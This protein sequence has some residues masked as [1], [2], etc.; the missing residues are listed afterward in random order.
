M[1][2]NAWLT[3]AGDR[4]A[5]RQLELLSKCRIAFKFQMISTVLCAWR[6]FTKTKMEA[7]KM[8]VERWA[9]WL[10]QWFELVKHAVLW[11]KVHL[12][13]LEIGHINRLR[14]Y[15][16]AFTR[17]VERLR[18]QGHYASKARLLVGHVQDEAENQVAVIQQRHKLSINQI[19]DN[20]YQQTIH[21]KAARLLQA[22]TV[23]NRMLKIRKAVVLD[24]FGLVAA[25]LRVQLFEA[26]RKAGLMRER[27]ELVLRG[28]Y[29]QRWVTEIQATRIDAL[30]AASRESATRISQ[31]ENDK[32]LLQNLVE[33]AL[34]EQ[35]QLTM[36]YH[37]FQAAP[38][39][40]KAKAKLKSRS[41]SPPRLRQAGRN[42]DAYWGDFPTV[43][44]TG[45]WAHH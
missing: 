40:K 28:R 44:R 2:F 26:A 37:T 14:V 20:F 10:S 32:L 39:P 35:E 24:T 41:K 22:R 19:E 13:A 15:F 31:L 18:M 29:L 12:R 3:A 43:T 11:R 42:P 1:A 8:L 33:E 25:L 36:E 4:A 30:E 21:V 23:V 16:R 5:A 27:K 6:R 7:N 9:V 34:R 38:K 45:L 17:T